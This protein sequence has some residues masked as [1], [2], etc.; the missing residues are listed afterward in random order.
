M[1]STVLLGHLAKVARVRSTG[2]PPKPETHLKA[3]AS[4]KQNG[5]IFAFHKGSFCPRK[6]LRLTSEV[7]YNLNM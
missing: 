4:N 6:R 3:L 2:A 5:F 1:E 7:Y